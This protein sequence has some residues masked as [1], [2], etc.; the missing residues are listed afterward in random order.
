MSTI[1]PGTSQRVAARLG[2]RVS[3][4]LDAAGLGRGVGG[5]KPV[6]AIMVR[7]RCADLEEAGRC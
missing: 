1:D 3:E 5:A 4:F 7:R 2:E 6:L